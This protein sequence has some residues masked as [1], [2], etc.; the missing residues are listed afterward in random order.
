[1]R[2]KAWKFVAGLVMA[3]GAIATAAPSDDAP[4]ALETRPASPDLLCENEQIAR[5]FG[6]DPEGCR[7]Y[8]AACLG[9][10]TAD[11]R[12]QWRRS[13]DACLQGDARLYRCYAEVP[14]C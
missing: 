8:L 1:M 9:E 7:Q 6:S 5:T 10:L 4:V 3:A 12:T 14:R 2:G 11:E 13:V